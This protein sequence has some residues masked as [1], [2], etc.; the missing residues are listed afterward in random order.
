MIAMPARAKIPWTCCMAAA[1]LAGGAFG[2]GAAPVRASDLDDSERGKPVATNCVEVRTEAIFSGYAYNH[3]VHLANGCDKPMQCVVRTEA[4]PDPT[5][6][7]LAKDEKKTV[8]TF[9]GSPSAEVK[10]DVKCTPATAR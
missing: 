5:T 3:F 4:T 6:V 8:S 7:N 1:V 9:R 2:G 10:A